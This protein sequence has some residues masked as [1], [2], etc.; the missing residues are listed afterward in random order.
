MT[1]LSENQRRVL[2]ELS[3][4][5]TITEAFYLSG[6]TALAEYYLHHR[7]S[8]DL[9]F[10]TP[11]EFPIEGITA[12]LK[13]VGKRSG[14]TGMRYEESFNRHLFFLDIGDEAIKTEFTYYPFDR[15]EQGK[16]EGA[17]AIDSLI[18]IAANK[19]FT[20]HQKPRAR[21]FID[22]YCILKQ[23][24]WTINDLSKKAKIKFDTHI[25]PIQL[26]AQFARA[27]ELKDY[28]RMIITLEP[29]IWQE[30]FREEA[31]RLRPSVLE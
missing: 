23:E 17:L 27:D 6:G 24:S 20:I 10:F 12:I 25:D 4:E 21:D 13:K 5:K 29:Q 8:E 22:L 19:L 28:P 11:D 1:I 15:I 14:V 26:G 9:D 7:Y 3:C 18:D 16:K 30:F 2:D 31:L